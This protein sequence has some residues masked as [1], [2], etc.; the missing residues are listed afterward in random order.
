[1]WVEGRIGD[2]GGMKQGGQLMGKE[3]KKDRMHPR[4]KEGEGKEI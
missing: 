2:E 3:K 1:M 4:Q